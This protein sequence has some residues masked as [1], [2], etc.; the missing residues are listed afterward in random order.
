MKTILPCSVAL[1]LLAACATGPEASSTPANGAGYEEKEAPSTGSNV[2]RRSRVPA[3]QG[4][5]ATR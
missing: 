1:L 2:S 4:A 3:P 5:P